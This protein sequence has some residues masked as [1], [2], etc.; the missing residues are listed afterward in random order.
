MLKS[1]HGLLRAWVTYAYNRIIGLKY[2]ENCVTH[3]FI[4]AGLG[5]YH[6]M[7]RNENRMF[8]INATK[9]KTRV[10]L[11]QH[12]FPNAS[13]LPL[14]LVTGLWFRH[15]LEPK[16]W[17]WTRTLVQAFPCCFFIPKGSK[18]CCTAPH[19]IG[20]ALG[21]APL[22]SFKHFRLKILTLRCALHHWFNVAHG[23]KMR[24]TILVAS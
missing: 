17:R 5:P 6:G 9:W 18:R 14:F 7:P 1:H 16:L 12:R 10:Q 24:K 20:I 11:H 23:R 3:H 13:W 8:K 2:I 22:R 19:A 4:S 21:S 15:F